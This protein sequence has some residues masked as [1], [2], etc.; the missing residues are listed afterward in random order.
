MFAYTSMCVH[1]CDGVCACD[2]VWVWD[3]AVHS[4]MWINSGCV[5]IYIYND[6]HGLNV[7]YIIKRSNLYKSFWINVCV[8]F[9]FHLHNLY[10]RVKPAPYSSL[11]KRRSFIHVGLLC[12]VY[13]IL[14]LLSVV[15]AQSN[16]YLQLKRYITEI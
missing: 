8:R 3:R 7:K 15:K 16:I 10:A 11:S 13:S 4:Y 14:F 12:F 1:A 5:F 9:L 6:R 2:T